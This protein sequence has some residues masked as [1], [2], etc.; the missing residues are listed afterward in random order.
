[1]V[2]LGDVGVVPVVLLAITGV[3]GEPTGADVVI[4]EVGIASL[5]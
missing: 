2:E 3:M 1:V 4:P 5:G